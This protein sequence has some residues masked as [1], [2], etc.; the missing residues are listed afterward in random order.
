GVLFGYGTPAGGPVPPPLA[1]DGDSVTGFPDGA[2]SLRDAGVQFEMLTVGSGEAALEQM[3]QAQLQAAGV[4]AEIRQLE[5]SAYLDRVEGPGHDFQAAVLG[6][7]GDLGLGHLARIAGLAGLRPDGSSEQLLHRIRDSVPAVFLYHA[8]G[9]Q[10]VN[11]RV[12]GIRMDLRG[13]LVTLSRWW[14]DGGRDP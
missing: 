11:R 6:V 2:G 9:V 14:V 12:R 13:E 3:L 1:A 4:R 8:R 5:L 7:S 10:G